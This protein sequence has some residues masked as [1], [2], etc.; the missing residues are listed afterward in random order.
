MAKKIKNMAR[1]KKSNKRSVKESVAVAAGVLVMLL[2]V[3]CTCVATSSNPDESQ[4]GLLSVIGKLSSAFADPENSSGYENMQPKDGKSKEA[5]AGKK[6]DSSPLDE[7]LN[8]TIIS[9]TKE[10]KKETPS[11]IDKAFEFLNI[12]GKEC[13][14]EANILKE[15]NSVAN[16]V[17]SIFLERNKKLACIKKMYDNHNSEYKLECVKLLTI[18][19]EI[20][21]Y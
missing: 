4:E 20:R 14:R 10:E 13:R 15:M 8:N 7:Q 1:A 17:Y 19:K 16:F 3:L 12:D 6:A 2:M 11:V 5:E 18:G 9:S 21:K